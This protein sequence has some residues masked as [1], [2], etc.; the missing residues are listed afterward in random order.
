MD[1]S[2]DEPFVSTD[3]H[4]PNGLTI[5]FPNERLYWTDAKKMSIESIRFD[6]TGRQVS[7]TILVMHSS[8]HGET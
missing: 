5:D 6:G 7:T 1:G 4:W 3:I 2:N 8:N